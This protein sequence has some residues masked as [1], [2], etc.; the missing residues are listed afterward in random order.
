MAR[1]P[2]GG[3]GRLRV[4]RSILA[5]LALVAAAQCLAQAIATVAYPGDGLAAWTAVPGGVATGS[6]VPWAQILNALAF[7]AVAALLLARSGAGWVATV[8]LLLVVTGLAVWGVVRS[9]S[10]A[11]GAGGLLQG[12]TVVFAQCHILAAAVPT[13]VFVLWARPGWAA[14][15]PE[16][17]CK[18][19]G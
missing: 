18:A 19:A 17:N 10:I 12:F 6:L 8:V 3:A 2:A 9:D 11:Q 15:E 4:F 7:L 16:S 14:E 5:G 1:S 13:L